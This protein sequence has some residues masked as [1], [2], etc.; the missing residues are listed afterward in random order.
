MSRNVA[1][2]PTVVMT[3][4]PSAEGFEL[5][6]NYQTN[7]AYKP[8][9]KTPAL[10]SYSGGGGLGADDVQ[11][12]YS[13]VGLPTRMYSTRG[14]YVNDADYNQFGD[15][16]PG[17]GRGRRAALRHG[18]ARRGRRARRPAPLHAPARRPTGP[19]ALDKS[20]IRATATPV[21]RRTSR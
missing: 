12:D 13:P 7:Y 18:A 3:E 19:L 1:Y 20:W 4:I 6:G 11:F 2:Q 10:I 15:P 17:A 21:A 8:D 5:D 16:A 9:A 14:T